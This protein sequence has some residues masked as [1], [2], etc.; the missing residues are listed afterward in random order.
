MTLNDLKKQEAELPYPG[1]DAITTELVTQSKNEMI[2]FGLNYGANDMTVGQ[3]KHLTRI[4]EALLSLH[5]G[6]IREYL[7]ALDNQ[8]KAS[9]DEPEDA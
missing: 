7:I 5:A 8:K 4:M 2:A 1:I 9:T 3:I 6:K